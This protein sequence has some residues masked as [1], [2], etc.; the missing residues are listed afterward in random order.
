MVPERLP[1]WQQKRT[2]TQMEAALHRWQE[3]WMTYMTVEAQL[4]R[5]QNF[6]DGAK[7]ACDVYK[8][9][10]PEQEQGFDR[11]IIVPERLKVSE[12]A[13][14]MGG[15]AGGWPY[16]QVRLP[17]PNLWNIDKFD[18]ARSNESYPY[19][20]WTV[21]GDIPDAFNI[22]AQATSLEEKIEGATLMEELLYWLIYA[23]ERPGGN[24]ISSPNMT[25]CTGSSL[26]YRGIKIPLYMY[27]LVRLRD[28]KLDVQVCAGGQDKWRRVRPVA[29]PVRETQ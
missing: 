9:T 27:P 16:D 26:L 14:L 1:R 8:I 21:A 25:L 6:F 22:S 29:A 12:L 15:V 2:A 17:N 3:K 10:I 7:I 4:F 23:S 13:E 18:N 24:L 5:W 28:H 19:A 11:L 20:V